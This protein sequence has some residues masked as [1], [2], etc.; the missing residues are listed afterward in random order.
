MHYKTTARPEMR[1]PPIMP[2]HVN[3]MH[4]ATLAAIY[5][6]AIPHC[7]ALN[8]RNASRENVENVVNPPQKPAIAATCHP[9]KGIAVHTTPIAN[10]PK[11]LTSIVPHGKPLHNDAMNTETAYLNALPTNPPTPAN[12]TYFSIFKRCN[13]ILCSFAKLMKKSMPHPLLPT[14]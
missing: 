1:I 8:I 10:E 4:T 2:S 7:P 3:N 6:T 13:K 14:Y 9:P 12:K 11:A 5:P